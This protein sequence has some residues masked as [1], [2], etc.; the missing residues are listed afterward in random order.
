[1]NYLKIIL[2]T[3]IAFGDLILINDIGKERKPITSQGA[4]LCTIFNALIIL[5]IIYI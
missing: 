2:I 3:L 1:M 4:V 5:A